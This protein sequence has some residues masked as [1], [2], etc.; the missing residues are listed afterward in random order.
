MRL[1]GPRAR[2]RTRRPKTLRF[3]RLTLAVTS[4]TRPGLTLTTPRKMIAG[5]EPLTTSV[6]LTHCPARS[7]SAIAVS[8]R[9]RTRRSQPCTIGTDSGGV[10]GDPKSGESSSVKRTLATTEHTAAQDRAV[11]HRPWDR[12]DS[13]RLGCRTPVTLRALELPLAPSRLRA[14]RS[15][16]G[17]RAAKPMTSQASPRMRHRS[18]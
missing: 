5:R 15:G 13:D 6:P 1:C 9:E 16:S 8:E 12:A 2:E 3:T 17:R 10:D 18:A 11:Q 7:V 4:G 14:R